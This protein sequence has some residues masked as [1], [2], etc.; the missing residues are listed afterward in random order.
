MDFSHFRKVCWPNIES[1][2]LS[3]STRHNKAM[4]F[5]VDNSLGPNDELLPAAYEKSLG[6]RSK[7]K[8]VL[9]NVNLILTH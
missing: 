8:N 4:H 6:N 9:L 5:T 3:G 7:I 2:P 1:I